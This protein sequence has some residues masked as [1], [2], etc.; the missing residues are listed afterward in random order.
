MEYRRISFFTAL[1]LG[2]AGLTGCASISS[3]AQQSAAESMDIATTPLSGNLW[4][5]SLLDNGADN[6]ATETWQLTDLRHTHVTPL[7]HELI[8]A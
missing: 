7:L 2:L 4:G 5:C 8:P 3:T 1:L 6:Q